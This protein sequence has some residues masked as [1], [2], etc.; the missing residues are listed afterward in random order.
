MLKDASM[1]SKKS[2]EA[3]LAL[4]T[5]DQEV[6]KNKGIPPNI[7]KIAAMCGVSHMTIYRALAK[8]KDERK[9]AARGNGGGR[10]A[11]KRKRS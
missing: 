4:F 7:C 2:Q 1:A 3:R 8:R 11:K 9:A 6:K 10:T 5:Y